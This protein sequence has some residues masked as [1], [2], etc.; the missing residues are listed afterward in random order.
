MSWAIPSAGRSWSC[1]AMTTSPPVRSPSASRVRSGSHNRRSPNTFESFVRMGSPRSAWTGPGG[2]TRSM[3]VRCKRSMPGWPGFV[4]SGNP[5]SAHWPP[6]SHAGSGTGRGPENGFRHAERSG[7]AD[8]CGRRAD[9]EAKFSRMTLSEGVQ[10][11]FRNHEWPL[12][13][14]A[15]SF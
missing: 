10:G 15:R 4:I 8:W 12:G 11:H 5:S 7:A 14:C 6:K 1:C 13:G 9:A 3:S 2:S